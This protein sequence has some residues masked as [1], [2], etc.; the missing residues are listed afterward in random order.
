[1]KRVPLRWSISCWIQIVSREDSVS[2]VWSLA[3]R[4]W[5]CIRIFCARGILR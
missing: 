5:Y 1:M 4:S 2:S 3:L